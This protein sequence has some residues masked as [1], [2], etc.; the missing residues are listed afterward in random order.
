MASQVYLPS[1]GWGWT[2]WP[3][4]ALSGP[5]TNLY[6]I[7][8]SLS[9]ISALAHSS[10]TLHLGLGSLCQMPPSGSH[11]HGRLRSHRACSWSSTQSGATPWSFGIISSHVRPFPGS[12]WASGASQ[13]SSSDSGSCAVT[14]SAV[15]VAPLARRASSSISA[16]QS[17]TQAVS[18]THLRAHETRHESRMPSSA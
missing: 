7:L 2:S 9:S 18:Y 16:S 10:W 4:Y 5:M 1:L 13:S 14:V 12:V 3:G 6:L 17:S 11:L 15:S 8:L